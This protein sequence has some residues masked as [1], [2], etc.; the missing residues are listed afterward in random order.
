MRT[1]RGLSEAYPSY[2]QKYS[3][4]KMLAINK[5]GTQYVDTF[6]YYLFCVMKKC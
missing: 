1:R 6:R 4:K 3:Y 5:N 2:R